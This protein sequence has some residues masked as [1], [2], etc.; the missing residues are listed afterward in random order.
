MAETADQ[1]G[2]A[3]RRRLGLLNSEE[4]AATLQVTPDTVQEW[5]NTGT[6]PRY[7]KLGKRVFYREEDVKDWALYEA[8]AGEKDVEEAR[9]AAPTTREEGQR[10]PPALADR[11]RGG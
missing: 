3:M 7:C 10:L 2:G 6:G 5:R 11:G 8:N 1:W 9:P 4:L